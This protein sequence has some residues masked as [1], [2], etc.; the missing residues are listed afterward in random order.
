MTTITISRQQYDFAVRK[1]AEQGPPAELFG[2]PKNERTR[3]FLKAV[4]E[5]G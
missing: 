4:L 3:Q 1:I 5:A 2:A